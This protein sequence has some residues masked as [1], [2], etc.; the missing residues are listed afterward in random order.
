MKKIVF[1]TDKQHP[2]L[3]IVLELSQNRSS[4]I[5]YLITN[6]KIFCQRLKYFKIDS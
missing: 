1:K 4:E 2:H 3:E 5:F 6:L